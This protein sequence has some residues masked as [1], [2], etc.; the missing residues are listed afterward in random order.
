MHA[1]AAPIISTAPEAPAP[2]PAQSV[3]LQVSGLHCAACADLL[4][5]RLE[6]LPGVHR[7]GVGYAAALAWVEFEPAQVD[8]AAL[9][10]AGRAA[11]YELVP[12]QP[13]AAAALRRREARA[14]LWRVFVAWFCMMQVM[15]MAAPTYFDSGAEV[16][17][18]LRALLHGA[19]W[20]LSLPVILFAAGPFLRGAWRSLQQRRLGMDVPVALGIL[21]TFGASTLAL[22]DPG[23]PLGDA[24]YL[25]SLTMFVAFLLAA[26]WLEL[27]ARHAAAASLEALG[28]ALPA[29]VRRLAPGGWETVARS[30]LRPGDRI[31]VALGETVPADGMLLEAPALLDEALLSGESRPVPRQ[32]GEAVV[33]GSLNLGAP[34]QLQVRAVGDQTRSAALG[35]LLQ[36]ALTERPAWACEADR[37]A[38]AFLALVLLLAAGAG[39]AWWWL[40]P[41]RAL[42]VVAAVLVV[43]CPCALA[44]AAPAAL[45]ASARALAAQGVW[46][47]RL[48]ALERLASVNH[49]VLDKTGTLTE[50]LVRA[51][52]GTEPELLAAAVGLAQWSRHPLAKALARLPLD[53]PAWRWSEVQEQPGQGLRALD[54]AGHWCW[55]GRAPDGTAALSFGREDGSQRLDFAVD[56]QAR[57]AARSSLERLRALGLKLSL[58]SGDRPE[59][60]AALAAQLELREA[61]GGCSPE[62]KRQAV[63]ALQAAGDCV[64][65]VGD[66]LNDAPVLAQAD[67]SVALGEGAGLARQGADLTLLRNE[68]AALPELLLQARRTRRVMRQNLA[69]AAAYN[70]LAVPLAVT[71]QL[72]PWAAGLGMALSSLLV[73]GNALR[74]AR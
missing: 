69:W 74:L 45:V 9:Q 50:P 55:L 43:T 71:G 70:L 72:P 42:G 44:L 34:L 7:A 33:A 65:M 20:V 24:V 56:E 62:D 54:P 39:L 15:M 57:P 46:L 59:R 8:L 23:G 73:V 11:G 53:R 3:T 30:A 17:P 19:S 31:Q 63:Q 58:L 37:W 22:A 2:S 40:A 38:P 64:L 49:V 27:R 32:P 21:L 12:A 47:Q 68:L 51:P 5:A 10:A 28:E 61:R 26:R 67:A 4:R 35:R 41:S 66:G 36:Q 60:V 13:E 48:P 25:D 14:M 52:A 1:V 29:E 6:A 18:D 16:P